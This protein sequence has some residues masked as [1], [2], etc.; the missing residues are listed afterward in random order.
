M[1]L[2]FAEGCAR[3][4]SA[5]ISA[6]FASAEAQR[7]AEAYAKVI[8][9]AYASCSSKGNAAGC[10]SAK[11]EATAYAK[12]TAEV[13]SL[14]T[15]AHKLTHPCSFFVLILH[16]QARWC[17]GILKLYHEH[18]TQDVEFPVAKISM[19]KMMWWCA[20]CMHVC[21]GTFIHNSFRA[22]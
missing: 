9:S 20:W 3:K 18:G 21:S 8:T 19:Y 16:T 11:S 1:S 12:A 17:L 5:K 22:G 13:W 2:A 14:S 4:G 7:F 6:A 15:P 10:A